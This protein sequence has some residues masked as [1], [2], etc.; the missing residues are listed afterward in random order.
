LLLMAIAGYDPDVGARL[1]ERMRRI[2]G[3]TPEFLSTH[4]APANRITELRSYAPTARSE[5]DR[6]GRI[7]GSIGSWTKP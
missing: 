5:A 4:P 6:I 7:S 1:W 3:H 2:S